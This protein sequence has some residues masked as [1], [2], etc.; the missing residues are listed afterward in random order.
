MQPN[1]EEP[2]HESFK[3]C[4]VALRYIVMFGFFSN[5][6]MLAVPMYSLQVLD[7][8]LSSSSVD[9]LILLTL[10]VLAI[11]V[12]F[13]MLQSARTAVTQKVVQ[14]LD[15]KLSPQLFSK[16][17]TQAAQ[18][19]PL[20]VGQELRDLTMIRQF[21]A[22]PVF[23]A[24]LDAPWSLIFAVMLFM[25]HPAI[26]FLTLIGSLAL[27]AIAIYEEKTVKP[28]ME[29]SGKATL[30]SFAQLEMASRNAEV[31][32]A[33]GMLPNLQQ[34]WQMQHE[35]ALTLSASAQARASGL[36]SISRFIR[37]ALQVLI[38]GVGAWLVLHSEMTSG[39]IIAGSILVGRAIAPLEAV[40]GGWSQFMSVR[41]AYRR[42]N[43]SLIKEPA[44]KDDAIVLPVP[45][46]KL[47]AFNIIYVPYGAK[48]PVLRNVTFRVEPGIALGIVG[49][50]GAGKSTLVKLMTGVWKPSAGSIRLDGA[51][52]HRWKRTQFGRHVGYLPQ[53]VE[54]FSGT[55][56][57]NIARM[58]DNAPDA[59]V[60]EAAQIAGVHE[61]ILQMPQGYETEIG[62][63]GA[64]LSGGQRQRIALA[65]A[66]FG[67]PSVLIL[68]EP[69]A[70]LDSD[71]ENALMRTID[72]AKQNR[73]T[74]VMVSHRQSL[75]HLAD[76][77]L[78]LNQGAVASFST[79]EEMFPNMKRG[80]RAVTA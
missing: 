23:A 28:A 41:E 24:I 57:Q 79:R 80:P 38:T 11:L 35:R 53:D 62:V 3:A 16:A 60:V 70:S 18:V 64:V 10:I 47:E 6:L 31:V 67:K 69:N 27:V 15:R 75:M 54:L 32:Q 63:G 13:T 30:N 39:S 77:I 72:W 59:E 46:G 9:T 19:K 73:I 2:L 78:T 40:I 52:V 45:L 26:G 4:R 25:L 5:L 51:E 48:K 68:D 22:G 37:F 33:M 17:V 21:V 1:K 20:N 65:R 42:L 14:W 76:Y 58:D 74:V 43:M 12:A 34:Q 71:G 44:D 8:V 61:M 36:G 50:S 56:R 55:I 29:E 7:R 66:V 49:A